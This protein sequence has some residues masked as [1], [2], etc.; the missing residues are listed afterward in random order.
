MVLE[1]AVTNYDLW[2]IYF[3]LGLIAF[4]ALVWTVYAI[5]IKPFLRG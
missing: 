4:L 1:H 3:C 5:L 2:P